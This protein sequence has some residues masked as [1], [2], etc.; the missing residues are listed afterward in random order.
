M[1]SHIHLVSQ[2]APP[3]DMSSFLRDF[4]KYTSKKFI[5]TIDSIDESSSEWFK[6]KFEFEARRTRRSEKY[7]IWKDGSHPIDLTSIDMMEK[8][9]YIHNNPV[10]AGLVECP[11][12]YLYSSARD[13]AGGKG[14]VKVT[15]I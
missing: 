3:G 11:G 2:A 13:Y 1:S 5:T 8:V 7:K 6:N 14:L 15:V 9:N 10:R 12:H 4:K